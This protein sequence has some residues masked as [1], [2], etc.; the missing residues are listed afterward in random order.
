VQTTTYTET[1]LNY[2]HTFAKKHD[3]SGLLVFTT[4]EFLKA[5]TGSLQ[6]SLPSRN[7][8]LSGRATYGYDSRYFFEFNF[9]YNGSERFAPKHRF[10]FFPSA[11][12]A[13]ILS[14][15]TFW[16]NLKPV[17]NNLKLRYSYG[18]VGNDQI[19]SAN[20]RFFYLSN[21]DP[22][23]TTIS[24]LFGT[25][26]DRRKY[27][28]YVTRYAD[29]DV[30]WEVSTK[31]NFAMELGLWEKVSLIAEYFTEYRR[32]ILM[33][34]AYIPSSMGLTAPLRANVG[35]ASGRGVDL[36][37]EYQQSWTTDFWTA[38]RGNFTYATS[39]YEVYEEPAYKDPWRYHVGRKLNQEAGYIAERLFMDDAEAENTPAQ[40][41]GAEY[42]GGDIKYTDVNRDGVITVADQVALGYPT[43]PEIVYGFGVSAG[44][45]GLDVSCFFQGV[46]NESFWINAAATSPFHENA[47]LLKVYA[48]DYWSENNQNMYATWPRLSSTI[49]NN[50]VPGYYKDSNGN[51]H[52]GTKNTWFMRD[53]SFLRLKQ[54]E[55]GYTIPGK[56]QQKI[57]MNNLRIYVSG[58]NL[59][60]FSKFKAWDIE[61]AG[62]GLGYPLQRVFN[63]GVNVTFN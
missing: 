45:K 12:V 48:D 44:Y 36:M 10:G 21:V 58:T 59:L 14:N 42:G 22:E 20:D 63:I 24:A 41:F 50:N 25:N 29:E 18:L 27:G 49:N 40:G 38:A 6:L 30:T 55:I 52:V 61:M 17:V 53:G 46:A 13:W 26:M 47:Q 57:H 23:N 28:Y 9:G 32:N 62:E 7:L 1:M 43:V 33:D 37:L 60:L 56:W 2:A 35:E 34:R 54:A 51:L 4:R 16:E 31:Q 19:G 15:E 3:V 5:N 8:G 11:G 39:R